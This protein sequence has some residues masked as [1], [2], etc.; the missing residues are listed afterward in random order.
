MVY[1]WKGDLSNKEKVKE[2]WVF[3]RKLQWNKRLACVKFL[4]NIFQKLTKQTHIKKLEEKGQVQ[5]PGAH[6]QVS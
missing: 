5:M 6:I 2:I 1:K 4:E 3:F